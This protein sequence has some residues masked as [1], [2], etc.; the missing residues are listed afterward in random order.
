MWRFAGPGLERYGRRRGKQSAPED[1]DIPAPRGLVRLRLVSETHVADLSGPTACE[2]LS[3][4]G[5]HAAEEKLGPDPLRTDA[6]HTSKMAIGQLLMRQDVIAGIGNIYR[7]ELLFRARINP[8]TP[9]NHLTRRQWTALWRD[10]CA[11]LA[12]G[13]RDGA[14][15]TTRPKD[16]AAD[17]PVVGRRMRRDQRSYVAHREGEACR[18]CG[19]IVQAEEMAGRRLY[20]CPVCQTG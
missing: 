18:V 1:G 20:W 12:D 5:K 2:I 16:R 19:N 4:E 3:D 8:H 14:I 15:V 6:I 11:L 13:V 17:K 9:G 10:T 7:A